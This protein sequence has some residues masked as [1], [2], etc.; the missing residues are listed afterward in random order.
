MNEFAAYGA[1]CT[2]CVIKY[3]YFTKL[4]ELN[5]L[6]KS[7]VMQCRDTLNIVKKSLNWTPVG[8]LGTNSISYQQ[9]QQVKIKAYCIVDQIMWKCVIKWIKCELYWLPIYFLLVIWSNFIYYIRQ[10]SD[11]DKRKNSEMLSIS[12]EDRI[13]W[14]A[15]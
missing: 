6:A 5:S 7:E 13:S 4:L 2:K 3:T 14:P 11:L 15:T 10:F 8:I 1:I 9:Q 12:S